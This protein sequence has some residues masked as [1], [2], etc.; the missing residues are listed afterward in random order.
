MVQTEMI[1]ARPQDAAKLAHQ[2]SGSDECAS[3]TVEP[4]QE[5]SPDNP[6]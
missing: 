4:E 6:E 1:D 5:L 2:G 3:V